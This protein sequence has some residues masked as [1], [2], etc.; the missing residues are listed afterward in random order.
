VAAKTRKPKP[1]GQ[2]A[3][4]KAARK[5]RKKTSGTSLPNRYT[6]LINSGE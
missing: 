3:G 2:N 4:G 1:P 5:D 6:V